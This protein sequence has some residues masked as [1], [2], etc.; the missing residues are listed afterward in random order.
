MSNNSNNIEKH[1]MEYFIGLLGQI[2]IY[3]W[4]TMSYVI[5][6]ALDE[7]HSNLSDNIDEVMEVYIG[8]YNRQPINKFEININANTDSSNI[9]DYLELERENIRG[10]RNKYFKSSS[11]IQNI[12]DNMLGS[13]SKTIYLCKLKY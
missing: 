12:F 4:S 10:I 5:H 3:H 6:K 13:I 9:L 2:K 8:K 1:L 11:E 7:L